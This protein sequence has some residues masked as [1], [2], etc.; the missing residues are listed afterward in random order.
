MLSSAEFI[1]LDSFRSIGSFNKEA[2]GAIA[3]LYTCSPNN[4]FGFNFA[5]FVNQALF[6]SSLNLRIEHNLNL[7]L[8]FQILMCLFRVGLL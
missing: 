6:S 7:K 1:N 5:A 8:L 2:I 3:S 4:G